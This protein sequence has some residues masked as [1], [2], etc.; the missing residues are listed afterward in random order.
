MINGGHSNSK[1]FELHEPI[2][3]SQKY[4]AMQKKLIKKNDAN[5]LNMLKFDMCRAE[6][7]TYDLLL[8]SDVKNIPE[9]DFLKLFWTFLVLLSLATISLLDVL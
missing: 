3:T 7:I 1:K 9:V 4:Q 2:F 8:F 5:V 6:F